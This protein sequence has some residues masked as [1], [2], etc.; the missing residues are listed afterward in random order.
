MFFPRPVV[1]TF[2]VPRIFK[3]ITWSHSFTNPPTDSK[4]ADTICRDMFR[5]RVM[6]HNH[7]AIVLTPQD[8]DIKRAFTK[9]SLKP[10]KSPML[11]TGLFLV[12]LIIQ[13]TSIIMCA[14]PLSCLPRLF[15]IY[16]IQHRY[17][18]LTAFVICLIVALMKACLAFPFPR[19]FDLFFILYNISL[20]NILY[21][22]LK[23]KK[24]HQIVY[25]EIVKVYHDLL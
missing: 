4:F 18:Y 1:D 25:R 24:T 15:I 10:T 12:V 9:F 8:D 17:P 11:N 6:S 13:K 14:P 22:M 16:F 20:G 21:G 7:Q 3:V 19:F 5:S 23:L 2:V